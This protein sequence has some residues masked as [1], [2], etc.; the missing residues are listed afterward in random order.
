MF[1]LNGFCKIIPFV[2]NGKNAISPIGELSPTSM[3]YSRDKRY[4]RGK[5]TDIELMVFDSTTNEVD[6]EPVLAY[7]DPITTIL[8]W[9]YEQAI[10]DNFNSSD[11]AAREL[12]QSQ[13]TGIITDVACGTMLIA[14]GSWF[15][16]WVSFVVSGSED[17]LIKL[18]LSDAAFQFQ[19]TGYYIPVVSPL[20]DLDI[21]HRT[22]PQVLEA[23]KGFN[24]ASH[25]EKINEVIG[26]IPCTN[27]TTTMYT[28]HD[29]ED[30]TSMTDTYW[31][32]VIYG[33]AGNNPSRRK[34][35]LQQHI[36]ANSTYTHAEWVKVFPEI[37][38]ST[39]FTF[40]PFW[41]LTTGEDL[42]DRGSLYSPIVSYDKFVKK[43]QWFFNTIE[44]LE[45]VDL[46][47]LDGRHLNGIPVHYKSL[48]CVLISG[49]NNPVDKSVFEL[50]YPDYAMIPVSSGELSRTSLKTSTFI[51][52]LVTALG[53]AEGL[54][55]FNVVDHDYSIVEINEHKFYTFE[56]DYVEFRIYIHPEAQGNV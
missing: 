29:R 50:I 38:T 16:T 54:Y 15:P 42:T 2:D 27:F 35:A 18:W 11:D 36:L 17:N 20:D 40:I 52:M 32:V 19:Y 41:E 51:R 34:R 23:L 3:T 48:S 45:S 4:Y 37:F 31:S 10:G 8:Q 33:A 5:A 47:N 9:V 43:A 14:K 55:E 56:H 6:I 28:W 26:G 24:I 53:Y 49:D 30:A 22:K 21:F 12:I 1:K 7:T 25:N 46:N 44:G 13:F 39:E